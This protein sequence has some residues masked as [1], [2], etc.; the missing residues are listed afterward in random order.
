M[1]KIVLV[2]TGMLGRQM[3]PVLQSL[4]EFELVAICGT[5]NSEETVRQLQEEYQIPKAYMNYSRMLKDKHLGADVIYLAVPNHLHY[6]MAKEAIER[7]YHVFVEK[8]FILSYENA[9][10][11]VQMARDKRL[12]VLEAISNQYVPMFKKLQ[13]ALPMVGTIRQVNMNFSQYSSRFD[14]FLEGEY[15]RVFDPEIGGGALMDINIYNLHL[16]VGL[17][18]YPSDGTYFANVMKDVDTSGTVVLRYPDFICT[19]IGAKDAQGPS[20]L[21]IEGTAGYLKVEAPANHLQAPLEFYDNRTKEVKILYRPD[22]EIHRM[23]Y[24][25]KELDRILTEKD[26]EACRIRQKE[27]LRVCKLA[28]QLLNG[29]WNERFRI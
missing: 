18:G 23:V 13:D 19:C 5:E 6:L 25:F 21:V 1:T 15:V 29:D 28:E 4:P 12:L 24:E 10:E 11:L 9:K 2:G 8:P 26:W 17:F 14:R 16:A 7:G 3:L 27:S 22:M 20:E